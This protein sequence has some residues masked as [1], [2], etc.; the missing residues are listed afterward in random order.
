MSY[1]LFVRI[2]CLKGT[3]TSRDLR[4]EEFGGQS[5]QKRAL[6]KLIEIESEN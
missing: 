3:A 5:L 4:R 6:G 2:N 1:L